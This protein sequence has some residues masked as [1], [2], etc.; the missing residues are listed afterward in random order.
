[1]AKKRYR[2]GDIIIKEGTFGKEMYVIISGK[3]RVF[4]TIDK[5]KFELSEL[6]PDDFFGEMSLFLS[7]PRTATV[8]AMGPTEVLVC[9]KDEFISVVKADPELAQQIISTM[10]KRLHEAHNVIIRVE[11]EKKSLKIMHGI[12]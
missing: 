11:G 5:K 6:G 1:M 3:A 4:K 7:L 12:K 10:A 8:Q 2:K 9:E